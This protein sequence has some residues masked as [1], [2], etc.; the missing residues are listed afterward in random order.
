MP[1]TRKPK[2]F[3]PNGSVTFGDGEHAVTLGG[4]NTL[5][6]CFFDAKPSGIPAVGV[7]ITDVGDDAAGLPLLSAAYDGASTLTDRAVRAASL[8]GVD[9]VCVAL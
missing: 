7:E 2:T 1:F 8:D 5:P 4:A 3:A 9:F 6:L